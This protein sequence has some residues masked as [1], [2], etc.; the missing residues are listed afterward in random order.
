MRKGEKVGKWVVV[1][2]AQE[3]EFGEQ[4]EGKRKK[5]KALYI[6]NNRKFRESYSGK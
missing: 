5:K 6:S 1:G 2:E 4:K 3:G